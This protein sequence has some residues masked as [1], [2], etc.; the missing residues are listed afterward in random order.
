MKNARNT[1][2]IALIALL[3]SACTDNSGDESD[4]HL[5]ETQQ[6][7]VERARDVEQDMADAARRQAEQIE[8]SEDGG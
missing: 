8:N 5:L 3:C 1:S 2:Y 7:A 6:Q 4:G